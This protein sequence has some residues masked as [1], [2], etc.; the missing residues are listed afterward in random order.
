MT[1]SATT[2]PG[3][4]P[5]AVG[6]P[7]LTVRPLV[8]AGAIAAPVAVGIP[9]STLGAG[10]AAGAVPVAVGMPASA[11][12]AA[13]AAG[14]VPVAVGIPERTLGA[15]TG[16]GAVPVAVGMPGS[17]LGAA[18]AVG[19]VP[20]AVGIPALTF[21][22]VVICGA[23]GVPV[24][25]GIPGRTASAETGCGAVPVAVGI[26]A[27]ALGAGTGAGDV[28][29]AVGMPARTETEGV[30]CGAAPAATGAVAG[31]A[32]ATTGCGDTPV[33]STPGAFRLR[34]GET[35]TCDC[36]CIIARFGRG[37]WLN[38]RF[39]CRAGP[40]SARFVAG[41]ADAK[42]NAKKMVAQA[43]VPATP[44]NAKLAVSAPP[45]ELPKAGTH[46]KTNEPLTGWASIAYVVEP[47]GVPYVIVETSLSAPSTTRYLPTPVVEYA[48]AAMD[49]FAAMVPVLVIG[50]PSTMAASV[51][52][53]A[54]PETSWMTMPSDWLP[55]VL[56]AVM[57]G[58]VPTS[59]AGVSIAQMETSPLACVPLRNTAFSSVIEL[60]AP[61]LTAL[62]CGLP[63]PPDVMK[64]ISLVPACTLLVYVT[65]AAPG[66]G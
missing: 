12:G 1:A 26:P 40:G 41:A 6:M 2:G 28:P 15:A 49:P 47:V 19:A 51:L 14:A 48:P 46:P 18:I 57:T 62:I 8:I 27:S 55:P 36:A 23:G 21:R 31:R 17:T 66:S 43:F 7:A 63:P 10:T 25:V 61:S 5:V 13:T 22:P 60:A 4:V 38:L 35:V 58:L 20:V 16:A 53:A 50:V 9:G 34:S 33:A 11:L 56:V 37:L 30:A 64:Q 44:V 54:S 3:A 24:A 52:P 32:S 65:V 59:P 42:L 29:V 39:N 45:V